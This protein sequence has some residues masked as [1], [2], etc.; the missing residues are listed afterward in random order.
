MKKSLL[1]SLILLSAFTVFAQDEQQESLQTKVSGLVAKHLRLKVY[2]HIL[3]QYA[4][5]EPVES[6]FTAQRVIFIANGEL[7]NKL[8]YLFMYDFGMNPMLHELWGRYKLT[9]DLEI[10]VGQQKVPFSIESLVSPS[11]LECIVFSMPT[12]Y[13]IGMGKGTDV[14]NSEKSNAGRDIGI[15]IDGK[16]FPTGNR[17]L[18]DYKLG[19]FNGSGI[20]VADNNN[21]KD[22]AAW[23]LFHPIREWSIGGSCYFGKSNY[24]AVGSSSAMNHRRNRWCVSSELQLP[25][26]YLRAEGIL[27]KDGEFDREGFYVTGLYHLMPEKLDLMLRYDYYNNHENKSKFEITENDRQLKWMKNHEYTVGLNYT[28]HKLNRLQLQY[29]YKDR[30][31]FG[32]EN[33]G[34]F[35][36][37]LQIGF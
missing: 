16:L 26:V 27:G 36:A 21:Y 12:T 18:I 32:Q 25:K 15:R 23:L 5:K 6:K 24:Q 37:Q 34:L 13:L 1:F 31:A 10:S 33:A 8:D 17:H 22:F 19:V 7:T 4:E 29:I 35:L 28:F 3:Y 11:S 20:N 14:M 30:Q 9:D 2:S